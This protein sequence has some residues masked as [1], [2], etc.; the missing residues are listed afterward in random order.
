MP[1][2]EKNR[3]ISE[4]DRVEIVRLY[5]TPLEDGTWM[6]TPSI[7]RQFNVT[8]PTIARWL[9]ISGVKRRSSSEAYAGG[10]RAKPIKNLPAGDAPECKCGCGGLVTWNQRKNRWNRYVKGHY[11]QRTDQNHAWEGGRSFEPY[12]D[13]WQMISRQIRHR[14]KYTCQD[15]GEVYG[16]GRAGLH[17][18][19]IDADKMNNEWSNLIT[20]CHRC[21]GRAHIALR[22]RD[23]LGRIV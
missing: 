22:K 10:K 17:V 15:C 14:D 12:A 21:H 7:A 23:A 20:L 9:R 19:H 16:R 5:T 3:K 8:V 11:T 2:G 4:A 1:R 13:D 6:G 18:H